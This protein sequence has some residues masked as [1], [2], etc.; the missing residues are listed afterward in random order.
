MDVRHTRVGLAVILGALLAVIAGGAFDEVLWPLFAPL[1]L[2]GPAVMLVT[3]R[4][5]VVR[6][7]VEAVA[8]LAGVALA[9]VLAGGTFGDV[10]DAVV[11]GPRQLLTTEWPSPA[12]PTVVGAVALL[13][14]ATTAIAADLAGRSR[15]HLAPLA[16]FA[17]GWVAALAIGAPVQPPAWVM[18]VGG[19]TALALALV[20]FDGQTADVR[21]IRT[22]RTVVVTVV[23][24]A[25]AA[26][27]TAGAV[28]WADRADPRR[29]EDAE[30]NAAVID[31]V[32]AVVA[33]RKA[34]PEFELYSITDRSL[35][36]GQ[37]LPARWRTSA[38][39]TYDGQRWVPRLTLRPIGGRLGLPSPPAA[40]RPPAISYSLRYLSDV[41]DLVPFPGPPLSASVDVETDLDRVVVRPLE[42]PEM[43]T[44]VL[45][46][47]EVALTSRSSLV[48]PVASRQVDEIAAGFTDQAERLAGDGTVV[49]RLRRIEE[50]MRDDW[51]LDPEA[52]GGGQQLALVERF[53]T[54]TN[55]G[56]EE[57]FVTAFVLMTRSLGFDAR[58]ATGFVVP[59]E[60]LET[61]LPLRSEMAAVWPEVRFD[62]AGWVA[63]D[64]VPSLVAVDDDEPP[65]QPEA[66]TPA[67]AQPP[68][69]PPTDDV[70]DVNDV[71]IEVEVGSG[72]WITFRRWLARGGG[73]VAVS[74]LPFLLVIGGIV[75]TK[76]LR[77]RRRR[78]DPDP[79]R[80]IRGVWA[81][82]TDSL[83][84]AGLT[85]GPS[86]TDDH[87]ATAGTRLAP[88]VPHE[89]RRLAALA[90][91]VTFGP[92]QRAAALADDAVLTSEA[93]DEAI[94][95]D[96]TGWKRVAWR[97]SLRSFR[98]ATR[99]PV[100]PAP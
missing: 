17:V 25:F 67:A 24:V 91:Q 18:V 54:D 66:Q 84:D 88:N 47:S 73:A 43:G 80:R 3:G 38:L 10:T 14:G 71:V 53:I 42:H 36:V 29:T 96:R 5:I 76:W 39:D 68:I 58:V 97:L 57:Q 59:P 48:G 35:V 77:R 61:P 41:L 60:V 2:V 37:S 20:R 92:T 26:V 70:D 82:A 31:P 94:R 8:V 64:P 4:R 98:R 72:R 6:V 50:T 1:L 28:A 45:I 22:D 44:T 51:Q 83:I 40:E 21:L 81:N 9:V 86:W 34:D 69:A 100:V 12:V 16:V 93:V 56:T 87:I 49:E 27:A 63:F 23:A 62:D 89:M 52:P 79:V 13:L 30:I 74:L 99:S 90:T 33:L 11:Q 32:E 15:L 55:R 46:E 7:A 78:L 19:L 85:I 65:P 75:G 95:S